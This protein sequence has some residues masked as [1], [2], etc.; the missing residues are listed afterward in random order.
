MRGEFPRRSAYAAGGGRTGRLSTVKPI[1]VTAAPISGAR[2]RS[3]L[4]AA[5]QLEIDFRQQLRI[6]QARRA[7]CG[8]NCRC[9]SARRARPGWARWPGNLRRAIDTVSI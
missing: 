9:R 7:W 2:P 1:T 6:E 5:A 4:P 8:W 3:R